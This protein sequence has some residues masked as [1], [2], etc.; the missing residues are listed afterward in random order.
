VGTKRIIGIVLIALGLVSLAWGGITWT[1]EKTVIDIGP[2][3]ARAEERER[4]PLPPA[5]GGVA[6]IAGVIL[7]VAPERRR[8]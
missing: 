4:I 8:V 5:L 3:Q 6:L 1:R 7:L 2:L